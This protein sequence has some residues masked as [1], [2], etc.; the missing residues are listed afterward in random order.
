MRKDLFILLCFFVLALGSPV[1]AQV[2]PVQANVSIQP[3][4][5]PYLTDYTVPGSQ[6]LLLQLSTKD[7]TISDHP[8]KLRITIEG[9]GITI[10]TKPNFI[11]QQ[12]T[13]YGGGTPTILYGEDLQEYFHP[14]NLDFAGLSRAEFSKTGKLP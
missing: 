10:R 6:K 8:I 4:Y 9:L 1:V 2:Y 3:P 12:H 13:L 14:N 5:S 11:P 7:I